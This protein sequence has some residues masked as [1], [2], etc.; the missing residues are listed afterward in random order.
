MLSKATRGWELENCLAEELYWDLDQD[1]YEQELEDEEYH[2]HVAKPL[3]RKNRH[4][5]CPNQIAEKETTRDAHSWRE[6]FDNAR[7]QFASPEFFRPN[8]LTIAKQK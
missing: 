4:K 8:K 1:V 7:E 3:P 6:R 2:S 5:T